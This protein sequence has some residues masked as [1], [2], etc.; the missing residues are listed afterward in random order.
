MLF[1]GLLERE[2]LCLEK[3]SDDADMKEDEVTLSPI[4][5]NSCDLVAEG[6]GAQRHGHP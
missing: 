1:H 4:V 2:N 3:K 5:G 6:K